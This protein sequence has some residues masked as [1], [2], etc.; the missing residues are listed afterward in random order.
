MSADDLP[1]KI[2]KAT[3]ESALRHLGELLAERGEH[4]EL[5]AGGGVVSVLF[6]ESRTMTEDVD[7]SFATA[8]QK[9]LVSELVRQVAA[10]R[11]LDPFWLND[12]V[13]K[14][15]GFRFASS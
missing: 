6:F 9:T 5:V 7:V 14:V 8:E 15:G 11:H 13:E 12:N 2:D 1:D 10:E 3:L 4:V